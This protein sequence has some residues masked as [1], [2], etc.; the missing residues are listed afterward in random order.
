MFEQDCLNHVSLPAKLYDK[1][2][3]DVTDLFMELNIREYPIDPMQIALDL[4]YDLVPFTQM[5]KEVKRELIFKDIDGISH[6]GRDGKVGVGKENI[7]LIFFVPQ[8]CPMKIAVRV[9]REG[10]SIAFLY[11]EAIFFIKD[12]QSRTYVL[13]GVEKALLIL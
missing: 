8:L 6:L 3:S 13:L 1:I 9:V 2:E 10:I 12:H 4:G 5:P 7:L 11:L